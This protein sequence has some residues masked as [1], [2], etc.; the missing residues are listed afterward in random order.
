MNLRIIRNLCNELFEKVIEFFQWYEMSEL[1]NNQLDIKC[2]QNDNR[3][4]EINCRGMKLNQLFICRYVVTRINVS[5]AF[6]YYFFILLQKAFIYYASVSLLISTIKRFISFIFNF[7][8]TSIKQLFSINLLWQRVTS[9]WHNLY[10]ATS[11]HG[12]ECIMMGKLVYCSHS[13]CNRHYPT[14]DDEI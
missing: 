13:M 2:G 5:V 7:I 3:E 11:Y 14:S 1:K 4:S 9:L 6:I 8:Q 10:R 12:D